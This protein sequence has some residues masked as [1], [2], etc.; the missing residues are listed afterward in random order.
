[1]KGRPDKNGLRKE[2]SPL[3]P[4]ASQTFRSSAAIL[5][6]NDEIVPWLALENGGDG[7]YFGWAFSDFGRFSLRH[8]GTRVVFEGGLDPGHFRHVLRP[9]EPLEVPPCLVGLFHGSVDDGLGDFHAFLRER[10]FPSLADRRFPLVQYN[11][12]TALGENVNE[13]NV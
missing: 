6:E 3:T 10:W 12:W 9:G 1:R 11:T 8:A 13:T 7:W 4:G 2:E 5:P